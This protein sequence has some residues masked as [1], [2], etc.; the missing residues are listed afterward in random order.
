[1]IFLQAQT[2]KKHTGVD[3]VKDKPISE[4]PQARRSRFVVLLFGRVLLEVR[5]VQLGR[6]TPMPWLLMVASLV[7]AWRD[8][9]IEKL[10]GLGASESVEAWFERT[11]H[12]KWVPDARGGSTSRRCWCA[13]H[14]AVGKRK[15]GWRTTTTGSCGS[16]V[17]QFDTSCNAVPWHHIVEQHGMLLKDYG[18]LRQTSELFSRLDFE[19]Y[20]HFITLGQASY[21]QISKYCTR[22]GFTFQHFEKLALIFTSRLENLDR[23]ALNEPLVRQEVPIPLLYRRDQEAMPHG[24][25]TKKPAAFFAGSCTCPMRRKLTPIATARDDSDRCIHVARR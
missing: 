3:L 19:R 20:D 2:T 6:T 10:P 8:M 16:S 15:L 22:G 11:T 18:P 23:V 17:S 9:D 12:N 24:Q 21:R 1:M 5:Q 25:L 7:G 14:V 13:S 4:G